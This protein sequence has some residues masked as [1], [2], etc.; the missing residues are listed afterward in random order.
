MG[1][2]EFEAL[3]PM[4]RA[5]ASGPKRC[6]GDLLVFGPRAEVVTFYGRAVEAVAPVDGVE[7]GALL[8]GPD[9]LGRALRAAG[10]G[11]VAARMVELQAVAPAGATVAVE[12]RGREAPD[13]HLLVERPAAEA[14]A[15][16]PEVFPTERALVEAAAALPGA[17]SS[18]CVVGAAEELRALADAVPVGFVAG[19]N[20]GASL[21]AP[22]RLVERLRAL[23]RG[24]DA[25][26]LEEVACEPLD[27]PRVFEASELAAVMLSSVESHLARV[28]G[29]AASRAREA[30]G[31]E[32]ARRAGSGRLV[33]ESEQRAAVAWAERLALSR[34]VSSDVVVMAW[35]DAMVER[36]TEP[37]LRLPHVGSVARPWF[38]EG[39]VR[40]LLAFR[41]R[42]APEASRAAF[43]V[44]AV[45]C[46]VW[47]ATG[48]AS[49][50]PAVVVLEDSER[51]ADVL[52]PDE[53][54]EGDE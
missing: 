30:L 41:P 7:W 20:R 29:A 38:F 11:G 1:V 46:R 48:G 16:A 32:S 47:T 23:G 35:G 9:L 19:R 40:A 4:L 52:R 28:E 31:A 18:V 54:A 15:R 26:A 53:G 24:A 45:L 14:Q 27:G 44:G 39:A 22:A 8:T 21:V 50:G 2:R 43:F 34:E 6:A 17:A 33:G 10:C 13:V 36:L 49:G 25:D 42:F 51:R 3:G 37:S 5:V 12:W